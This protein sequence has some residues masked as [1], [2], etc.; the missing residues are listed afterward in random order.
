M[1]DDPFLAAQS[2]V[3]SLLQQSRP[4]LSSYLRIR[5]SASSSNSP[6]LA[7]ARSELESTLTDISTDLE[8]LVE[9]V[10][11]VEGDP[12]KY[13]LDV[14][15]VGRRRKLVADVGREV[16]EMRQKLNETVIAADRKAALA[17]PDAFAT[18]PGEDEDDYGAW[19]EQRQMEMMHEQDEALDGV[20]QTVGNLRAQADTMGRELEEQ[21]EMLEDTENITDR[22]G[23]KLGV[24]MKKIRYVIEKNE[25]KYSSCCI[26]MLIIVLIILLMF[27]LFL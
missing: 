7:E 3:L 19:E 24:G 13:G 16:E 23:S 11:A 22:V 17:H 4:L 14:A 12:Y 15:E 25:D 5:S 18:D 10:R 21:A 2:D 26:S 9:S 1:S 20:F 8:D 6:E 27:V